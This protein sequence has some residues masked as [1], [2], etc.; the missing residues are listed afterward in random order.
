[1]E[2]LKINN[3]RLGLSSLYVKEASKF[4]FSFFSNFLEIMWYLGGF[5][6]ER[7]RVVGGIAM[8]N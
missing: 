3:G 5:H 6:Y 4:L 8:I 2:V 7:L 1:M